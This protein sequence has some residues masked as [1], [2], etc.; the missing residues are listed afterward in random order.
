MI[1]GSKREFIQVKDVQ[2]FLDGVLDKVIQIN[3]IAFL[4]TVRRGAM[5]DEPCRV[6]RRPFGSSHAAI[7]VPTCNGHDGAQHS[8][9]LARQSK[10]KIGVRDSNKAFDGDLVIDIRREVRIQLNERRADGVAVYQMPVMNHADQ[11]WSVEGT[12]CEGEILV[13][14]RHLGCI[15]GVEIDPV[16]P[17]FVIGNEVTAV[18][19]SGLID[20]AVGI[21]ATREGV[22]G[23]ATDQDVVVDTGS[24]HY[25]IPLAN[26]SAIKEPLAEGRRR[27]R[28]WF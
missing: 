28:L 19:E 1:N 27:W 26:S 3:L 14:W 10:N 22:S 4:A 11:P 9:K 16:N 6:Y 12:C 15:H 7:A 5:T 18:E 20:E 8:Y 21:L 17:V 13:P 25:W 23:R 2:G 24:V